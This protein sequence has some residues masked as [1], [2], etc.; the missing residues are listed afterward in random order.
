MVRGPLDPGFEFYW[1]PPDLPAGFNVDGEGP[2]AIERVHN[3]V[4]NRRRGQFTL[5]I[6]HARI[7]DRHQALDVGFI[8]LLERTVAFAVVTHALGCDVFRV[9]AVVDE[10][11]RRLGQSHRCPKTE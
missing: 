6:H 5:I 11:F 1:R 10:I 2:L 7:P 3:A 4:V 8:D 9:L